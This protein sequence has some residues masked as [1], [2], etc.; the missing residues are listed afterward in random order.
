MVYKN[1]I[2]IENTEDIIWFK[3]RPTLE[4][5]DIL[6]SVFLFSEDL[7]YD[8]T[9]HSLESY[10]HILKTKYRYFSLKGKDFLAYFIFEKDMLHV[11]LRKKDEYEKYT[12][13]LINSLE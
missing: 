10:H 7:D 12:K 8:Y 9:P 13:M 4:T 5:L 1:L 6:D 3:I 2:G 11:I